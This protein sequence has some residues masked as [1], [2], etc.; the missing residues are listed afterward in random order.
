MRTADML[1]ACALMLV[2]LLALP[3]ILIFGAIAYPW[4]E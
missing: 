1:L 2:I 3:F 4:M